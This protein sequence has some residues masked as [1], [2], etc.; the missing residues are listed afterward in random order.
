[1]MM[2]L[3]GHLLGTEVLA[4]VGCVKQKWSQ[5]WRSDEHTEVGPKLLHVT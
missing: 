3:V 2:V 5:L 4:S 1:M